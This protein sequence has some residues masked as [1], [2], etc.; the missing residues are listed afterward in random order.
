MAKFIKPD[1]DEPS[2]CG[3]PE[4]LAP[5]TIKGQ[6]HGFPSDW[7][8]LGILMFYFFFH[9]PLIFQVTRWWS[10]FLHFIIRIRV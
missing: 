8:A 10:G 9:M 2:L 7:W 1:D 3:T 4:Y 5:E 6:G